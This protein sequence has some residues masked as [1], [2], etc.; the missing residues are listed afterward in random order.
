MANVSSTN[1]CTVKS[2]NRSE[3]CELSFLK[4]LAEVNLVNDKIIVSTDK[5]LMILRK[6]EQSVLQSL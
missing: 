6:Y 2:K 5:A 4:F 3:G 1:V